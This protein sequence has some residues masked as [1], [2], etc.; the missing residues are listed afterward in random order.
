LCGTAVAIKTPLG[1]GA[2]TE[3]GRSHSTVAAHLGRPMS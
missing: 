3:T 1:D 2:I